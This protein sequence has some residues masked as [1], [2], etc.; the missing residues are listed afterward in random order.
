MEGHL[1]FEN[2][3]VLVGEKAIH[4][5]GM[6]HATVVDFKQQ[7]VAHACL[8][9]VHHQILELHTLADRRQGR[10]VPLHK[11][12]KSVHELGLFASLPGFFIH[13][14]IDVMNHPV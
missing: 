12:L 9:A 2:M 10:P 14:G 3:P 11:V 8:S 5:H 7:Q 6:H 13:A 4:I 1:R